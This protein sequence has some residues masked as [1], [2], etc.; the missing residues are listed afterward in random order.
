M[1]PAAP[2]DE[3]PGNPWPFS[4]ADLTAG[5]RRHLGDASIQVA[6]IEPL[7]MTSRRPSIGR[8]RALRVEARSQRGPLSIRWPRSCRCRRRRSSP[9]IRTGIGCCWRRSRPGGTLRAGK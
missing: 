2:R 8:V 1:T 7:T 5:L 4:R 3:G 9:R 6:D